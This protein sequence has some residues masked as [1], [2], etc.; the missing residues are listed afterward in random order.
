MHDSSYPCTPLKPNRNGGF[1]F[2]VC[3]YENRIAVE[4]YHVLTDGMG[5]MVFL[6][7]LVAEY[8]RLRY[9]AD[10]PRDD[11]ILDCSQPASP[12]EFEDSF[13]THARKVAGRQ[14]ESDAY[15]V[16]GTP[17]PDGFLNI[18]I[19]TIPLGIALKKAKEK[20]VSLTTYLTSVL[21]LAINDIQCV[22]IRSRRQ[23]MPVKITVPINLRRFFPS[24]TLRNFSSFVNPGIDPRL[25]DYTFDEVL[26]SVHYFMGSELMEKNLNARF[27]GNVL[28]EKSVFVRIIPLFIK[29]FIMKIVFNRLGDRKCSSVISNLGNI[30]LPDEMASY[31]E[32]MDFTLGAPSHNP[33]GCTMLS[34]KGLIRFSMT[35]TI[36]ESDVERAFFTRLVKLGIPVTI[37]SNQR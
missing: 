31:V 37:E 8:L 10:I 20:G 24:R 17:E 22:Q 21:I 30:H 6:K 4:I 29:N 32:R 1:S 35:R 14:K 26:L 25:G 11:S 33:V 23:L 34:Y 19:G 28:F 36:I 12:R 2:R 18:T 9:G 15:H 16:K 13:L 3:Y 5:G 27:T 7:T